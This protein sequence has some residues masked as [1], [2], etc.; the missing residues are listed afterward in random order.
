MIRSRL[1]AACVVAAALCLNLGAPPLPAVEKSLA[2]FLSEE[3]AAKIAAAAPAEA[4][5]RPA[6]P[7]KVLVF[8]EGKRGLIR[9]GDATT[10]VA[11]AS[12]PHCA[13]AVAAMGR[14]TGAYEAVVTDDGAFFEPERL[15]AFDAVVLANVYLERVL[16][17]LD[18]KQHEQ[19]A[20]RRKALL[21]FVAGGK[22]IV[23][24]H[25]A[26]IEALG[27]PEYNRM[28]GGI[29]RGHAWHAPQQVPID[30][31][32]PRHPLTAAFEGKGFIIQ[33]DV[34]EFAAPY[35]RDA[36]RVLLSVYTAKAPKSP[37][38]YRSDGDYPISWV[39]SHEKGRVF[40][41]A[42]GHNP[43]TFRNARVLRHILAGIQFALGDLKADATPAGLPAAKRPTG[44][45][46]EAGWRALFNGKDLTGW[47]LADKDKAHWSVRDGVIRYDG[48]GPDLWTTDRFGDFVLK[49]DWRFPR[50]GDSG[51]FVRGSGKAQVNIWTWRMGSGELWGYRTGAKTPEA[52]KP[53][54]PRTNADKPVGEWNTFI[55]T[56]KGDR[57][58]VVLNGQE[59][60]SQAELKG[61]PAAG[62][63]ALQRHGDPLEFKAI[64]VKEL[65]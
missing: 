10:Y 9:R 53:F 35:S 54:T 43:A 17:S 16:F 61:V 38:A 25:N 57:L 48:Q 63:I 1:E 29:H 50:E 26:T 32:D 5:A 52:Q 45:A 3:D 39:R 20:P 18:A 31:D 30:L 44:A 24:I 64:Y 6:K 4:S 49:V 7:R 59:V 15:K 33:D 42:L 13:E 21:E 47:K 27:W 55:L 2:E 40:Y 23:G 36:V 19:L 51:V 62:P 46:D 11:H 65:K 37:T 14:K 41:T 34:Y 56:M 12:A 22:G 58:T 8:T 28:I 60:I